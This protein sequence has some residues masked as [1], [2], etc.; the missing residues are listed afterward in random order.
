M[1][2]MALIRAMI[3]NRVR[4]HL[5]P[6]LVAIAL[7]VTTAVLVGG[8]QLTENLSQDYPCASCWPPAGVQMTNGVL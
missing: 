1:T 4:G 3:A 5:V 6:A 8:H 7:T 2:G